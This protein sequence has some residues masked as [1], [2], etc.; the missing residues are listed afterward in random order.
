[1]IIFTTAAKVEE[2]LWGL[3]KRKSPCS[4]KISL[5]CC[6]SCSVGCLQLPRCGTANP[7]CILIKWFSR[8]LCWGDISLLHA[9][10]TLEQEMSF[11]LDFYSTISAVQ[12]VCS[13]SGLSFPSLFPLNTASWSCALQELHLSKFLY[14]YWSMIILLKLSHMATLVKLFCWLLYLDADVEC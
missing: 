11:F 13:E 3:R 6:L 9:S 14:Q 10:W 1:M 4:L 7:L 8:C 2:P 5:C 12:S